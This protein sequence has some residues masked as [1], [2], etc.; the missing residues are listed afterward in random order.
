MLVGMDS[1]WLKKRNNDSHLD[2]RTYSAFSSYTLTIDPLEL[3][4]EIL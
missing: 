4:I 1:E 2:R 3:K